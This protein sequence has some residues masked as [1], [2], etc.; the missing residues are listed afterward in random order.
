MRLA[1]QQ[2]ERRRL[3]HREGRAHRLEQQRS[4]VYLQSSELYRESVNISTSVLQLQ[5]ILATSTAAFLFGCCIKG[6]EMKGSSI[7]QP[8][9]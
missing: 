2:A 9:R 3:I 4:V 1:R 5:H 7:A 8:A 6:K